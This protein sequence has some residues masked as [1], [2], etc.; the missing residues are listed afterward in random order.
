MAHLSPEFTVRLVDRCIELEKEVRIP[1]HDPS[2]SFINLE[3][4]RIGIVL[5]EDSGR[6]LTLSKK[7]RRCTLA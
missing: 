5:L 1:E 2:E 6:L 4:A 7:Q 3:Q